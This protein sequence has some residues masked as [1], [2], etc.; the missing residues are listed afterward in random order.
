MTWTPIWNRSPYDSARWLQGADAELEK[1]VAANR[2]GMATDRD[3]AP[4]FWPRAPGKSVMWR[5]AFPM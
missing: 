5:N 2:G 3:G 4:V 1:F